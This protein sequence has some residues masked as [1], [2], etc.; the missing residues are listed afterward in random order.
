MSKFIPCFIHHD[1]GDWVRND[2]NTAAVRSD[3]VIT[4]YRSLDEITDQ[5]VRDQFQWAYEQGES[6]VQCGSHVFQITINR[7]EN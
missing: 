2:A 1:T 6:V 5:W 3:P 7:S 4:T